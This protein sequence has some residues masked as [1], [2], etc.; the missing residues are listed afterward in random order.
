ML[1]SGLGD[2]LNA[3]RSAASK[4]RRASVFPYW[5]LGGVAM[6]APELIS[7]ELPPPQVRDIIGMINLAWPILEEQTSSA[8]FGL[9]KIDD[10]ELRILLGRTEIIPR[11]GKL[12]DILRHRKDAR[13][14]SIKKLQDALIE[15]R[16]TRNA[17]A[18]GFYMGQSNLGEYL[19]GVPAD[20]IFDEEIDTAYK[21]RAFTARS[22]MG[23]LQAV[24]DLISV[25]PKHFDFAEMQKLPSAQ[26]RIPS[27]LRVDPPGKGRE[28]P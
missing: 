15:L 14:G 10:V 20:L 22:L 21:M 17:L 25:I 6:S 7:Q 28:K 13:R 23:H 4:R 26:F 19:I 9:L 2:V 12:I 1:L 3:P 27:D 24:T 11:L 18:H 5:S 8:I 16:P